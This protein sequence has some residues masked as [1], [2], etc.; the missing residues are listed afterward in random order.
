[1]SAGGRRH[2]F[3][4]QHRRAGSFWIE[5][6]A[7]LS[8][9]FIFALL[10][11]H[12]S[13]RGL[14]LQRD[15][16]PRISR[17]TGPVA[18]NTVTETTV[19]SSTGIPAAVLQKL[20]EKGLQPIAHDLVVERF[21]DPQY[22]HAIIFV[23]A[24]DDAHYQGGHI[25]GAYQFN[26]Y[27]MEKY[28]ATVLPVCLDATNVIVYCNG[29]ECED[30]EFAAITLSQAGVPLDNLFIYAGGITEWVFRKLPIETGDR[31]SGQLK[32]SKP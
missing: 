16:F 6:I 3:R 23:D 18:T 29:G 26:S 4:T 32:P 17:P 13:P 12:L 30:S 31:N 11:N 21:H 24:R 25:P 9:G 8:A 28:F 22:G 2:N 10:A 20:K 15:Y 19:A 14:K 7:V 5:V 1:M 27:E